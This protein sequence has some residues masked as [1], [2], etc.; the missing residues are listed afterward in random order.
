MQL[1]RISKLTGTIEL[2]TGLHIGS[3]N[4]EMHIGGTDNPVIKNPLTQEPYI[5]GSSLKGKMR[6]LMEWSAGVVGVTQGKPLGFRDIG[7]LGDARQREQGKTILRLFGGAPEGEPDRDLLSEIGPT[8]LAFWD[9]NLEADWVRQIREENLLLTETKMEN[10]I[11]RIR[12]VA[13]HPRNTERVPASARFDFNLTVR[14][15][16][17]EDLLDEILRGLRLVELT[18]LGGSGSRGYGK[19]RFLGL[20]LDGAEVQER[21]D[22]VAAA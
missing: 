20:R 1:T 15:H 16:D 17:G 5:P 8:R 22:Q 9:C 19:L 14:V 2:V 7:K 3:G 10:A 12:G 13:E 11:D 6:S 18:G 21:Y 4:A